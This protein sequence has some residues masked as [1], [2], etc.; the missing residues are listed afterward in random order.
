MTGGPVRFTKRCSEKPVTAEIE[1]ARISARGALLAALL[2]A[3]SAVLVAVIT[4]VSG[5][6]LARKCEVSKGEP[7]RF[8][9]SDTQMVVNEF[10][11]PLVN[12]R[13]REATVL[14]LS[15]LGFKVSENGAIFGTKEGISVAILCAPQPHIIISSGPDLVRLQELIDI[16]NAEIVRADAHSRNTPHV[17]QRL[18]TETGT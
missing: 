2:G 4:E 17:Q 8:V 11:L 16:A 6:H 5:P 13:C 15:R 9:V 10:K 7:Q 3:S 1:T 12:E 14:A 18:R